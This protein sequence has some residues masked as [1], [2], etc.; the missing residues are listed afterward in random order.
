MHNTNGTAVQHTQCHLPVTVAPAPSNLEA[1]KK[2]KQCSLVAPDKDLTF[3][4][5]KK[6]SPEAFSVDIELDLGLILKQ[7]SIT[8]KKILLII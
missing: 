7:C 4:G 1:K 6:S 8:K 3:V 5:Q 2:T